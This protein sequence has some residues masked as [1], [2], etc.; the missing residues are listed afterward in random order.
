LP[1]IRANPAERSVEAAIL[2][3]FTGFKR[4]VDKRL[5]ARRENLEFTRSELAAEIEV[6]D[7]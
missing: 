6:A 2:A 3:D 5:V 7:K 4:I 1:E